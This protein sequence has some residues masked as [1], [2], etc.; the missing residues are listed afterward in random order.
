[1][2]EIPLKLLLPHSD[3][4]SPSKLNLII[5]LLQ[6]PKK[7]L[8]HYVKRMIAMKNVKKYYH[9]QQ[10]SHHCPELQLKLVY[11]I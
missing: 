10:K 3:I 7:L 4:F 8:Y 2:L 1:M 9:Q 11:K 6:Y 5:L